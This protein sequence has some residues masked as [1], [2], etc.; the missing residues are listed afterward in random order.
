MI[1]D[2][3]LTLHWPRNALILKQF[4]T[5]KIKSPFIESAIVRIISF[6]NAMAQP[7]HQFPPAIEH[8][9][10][11]VMDRPLCHF[12][13]SDQETAEKGPPLASLLALS[14]DMSEITG[15]CSKGTDTL[16][17]KNRTG[18]LVNVSAR[19]IRGWAL[20]NFSLRRSDEEKKAHPSLTSQTVQQMLFQG[21]AK[22][23]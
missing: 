10:E 18:P 8:S 19:K 7:G 15:L 5:Q 4:D 14:N 13:P 16:K 17:V 9:I 12:C 21:P 22:G 20:P 3:T 6:A 2:A 11:A 23:F 1:Y